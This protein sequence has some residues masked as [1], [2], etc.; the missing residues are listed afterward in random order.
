[1]HPSSSSGNEQNPT[2]QKTDYHKS[3][4][5]NK[6][7]QRNTSGRRDPIGYFDDGRSNNIYGEPRQTSDDYKP[8][9]HNAYTTQDDFVGVN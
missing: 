8:S 7:H 9:W 3:H 1:M 4:N 2:N 5:P 6:V